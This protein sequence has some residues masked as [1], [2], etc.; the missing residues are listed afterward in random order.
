MNK[1]KRESWLVLTGIAL[2][3]NSEVVLC[4]FCRYAEWQGGCKEAYPECHHPLDIIS[5]ACG[6]GAEIGDD[7]WGFRPTL[8]REDAVDIVGIWL[9]G[10]AIDFDTLKGKHGDKSE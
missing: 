6:G 8:S 1:V 5:D 10:K 2:P 3:D 7:C 4:C 9:Q